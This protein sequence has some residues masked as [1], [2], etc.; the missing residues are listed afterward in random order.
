MDYPKLKI[1]L[2]LLFSTIAFGTFGYVIFE[3]MP[4]FEAFYM[5]LITIS[6]VGF[7]EIKPLTHVGRTITIVIIVLGI[8]LL[9]YT[10]GQVARIFVEGELRKILGRR[11]LEKQIAGLKDHYIICGYGRI[12][13]IIVKELRS[14]GIPLIVIEQHEEQ[15]Q[16]LE[17]ENVLYLN[18]DATSD[19]S[20]IEAG[21]P[22]AVGLV[23]AVSSDADNVY[24]SLSAKQIRPDIFILARASDVKNETKLLRAGA[25][26]VVC[27]YQIG[28]Q[29]MAEILHKPTVVDFLD[30]ALV[31]K[32]LDLH[33]EESLLTENSPIIGK[34]VMESQLRLKYGVMIIAI[35]RISGLMVF[36]PGPEVEF[37]AGD[38]IVVIGQNQ[39]LQLMKKEIR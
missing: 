12:G 23:T 7:S 39:K 27:P 14:A 31:N 29:R 38:V 10:L 32:E 17:A 20:L 28:A 3:D 21:L 13:S 2:I 22:R 37:K 35:K 30:H 34:S 25:S 24:I 26:R 6:T 36:N 8:S 18:R 5:T 9:T 15:I 19:E 11:K 33:I 4:V 16:M 1:S